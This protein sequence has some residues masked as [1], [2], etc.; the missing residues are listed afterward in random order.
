MSQP[1]DNFNHSHHVNRQRES[2][3]AKIDTA[4]IPK[5]IGIIMDGN[6]RWARKQGKKRSQ[7]HE[8]GALAL[9]NLIDILDDLKVEA[10]SLY[11]FSEE[12]WSRPSSEINFL[13]KL[14]IRF[15]WKKMNKIMDHNIRIMH[16]G[17]MTRLPGPV[18]R[19]I[20][21]AVN[22][23]KN[24]TG[25]IVN[26][27]VNYG[28]RQEIVR[29]V[30]HSIHDILYSGKSNVDGQ[31]MP[32]QNQ[33]ASIDEAAMI[34]NLYTNIVNNITE[35]SIESFL[36]TRDLPELDLIIRTS[37]EMRLSNFLLWQASYSELWI[38][39]K[40]W[41]DFQE[42]DLLEAILDYQKRKRKYGGLREDDE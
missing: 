30:K 11:S 33:N 38:T 34:E 16:S 28:S 19:A 40:L 29:A 10:V 13:W 14:L 26:Y 17:E 22:K 32:A 37:G 12:N 20:G 2:L 39:D 5:H 9:E 21:R 7:G 23:T 4:H 24:N 41:P 6:G 27:C 1:K 25:C 8:A 42:E 18:Q 36:Y 3:L 35:K 15:F 31:F